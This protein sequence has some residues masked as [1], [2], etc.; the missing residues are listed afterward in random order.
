MRRC[1]IPSAAGDV[2]ANKSDGPMYDGTARIARTVPSLCGN[3][4]NSFG[5]ES[6]SF[7]GGP[8]DSLKMCTMPWLRLVTPERISL[9]GTN[10]PL[11]ARNADPACKC[12][13]K[14]EWRWDV[15]TSSLHIRNFRSAALVF[16]DKID[17]IYSYESQTI[18]LGSTS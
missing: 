7:L 3:S 10:F 6:T 5:G 13:L 4:S 8:L 11:A 14:Y 9:V 15:N 2:H 16:R 17:P 18:I 12:E 1:W